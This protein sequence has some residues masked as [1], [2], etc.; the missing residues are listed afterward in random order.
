[1]VESW[2][3][4]AEPPEA[5]DPDAFDELGRLLLRGRTLEEVLTRLTELVA[6]TVPGADQVSL[7]VVGPEGAW[8]AASSGPVAVELD[9]HQ[10]ATGVGPCL[11]A[12][13]DGGV[14]R[15]KDTAADE[16]YPAFAAAAHGRGVR[17][18]FSIGLPARRRAPGALNLYRVQ[19]P[20]DLDE[21]SERLVELFASFA[22][23]ALV[24]AGPAGPA[25]HRARYLRLALHHRAVVDQATGVVMARE[26]CDATTARQLLVA[27]ARAQDRPL[28]EV[29]AAVVEDVDRGWWREAP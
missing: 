13:S 1:V 22:A 10:Y 4:G 29:A 16:Q 8:T 15:V 14:V 9:H 21:Q 12:A 26:A 5:Q 23:V 11:D 7:T 2:D 17:S 18:S 6:A 28:L 24:N 19:T 3:A 20:E 27:R 25:E